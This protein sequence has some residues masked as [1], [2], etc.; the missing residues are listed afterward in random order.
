[1]INRGVKIL[2]DSGPGNVSMGFKSH[3]LNN[4]G[5]G[6]QEP[7][8]VSNHVCAQFI[9]LIFSNIDVSKHD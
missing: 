5:L 8:D 9:S 3:V 6:H 4:V 2:L 1:L 7:L